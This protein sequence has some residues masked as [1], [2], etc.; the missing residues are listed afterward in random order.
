EG[1]KEF[2]ES[3]E[4]A[5]SDEYLPFSK[6]KV[7]LRDV[8]HNIKLVNE[9]MQTEVSC[10]DLFAEGDDERSAAHCLVVEGA[11]GAGKSTLLRRIA[12]DFL[13]ISSEKETFKDLRLFSVLLRIECRKSNVL[14]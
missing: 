5:L 8:F 11:A 13:E 7:P 6:V 4:A 3:S 10:E 9:E 14:T 1:K 12:L 2:K